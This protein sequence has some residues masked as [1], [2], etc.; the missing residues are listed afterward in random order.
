MPPIYN[1]ETVRVNT[2]EDEEVE[3][4]EDTVEVPVCHFICLYKKF[5]ISPLIPA[6]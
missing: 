5:R 6:V 4:Q 1:D 2:G 3:D